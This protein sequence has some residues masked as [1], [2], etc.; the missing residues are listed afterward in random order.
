M[1]DDSVDLSINSGDKIQLRKRLRSARRALSAAQ[2]SDAA[3]KLLLRLLEIN[4]FM[5]SSRIA[6]YLANDGEI[7]PSKLIEWCAQNNR[8]GYLPIVRQEQE[9]NWL[10][11]AEVTPSSH[12][13]QNRFGIQ[14]PV[15]DESSWIEAR[16]LDLVLLPLVGFDKLGNRIGMGGGFY[17]TTFEFLKLERSV[18]K[19]GLIGVAHEIQKVEK[20]NT[21]SWDV[22]L[23][24]VVT[25]Q[26]IYQLGQ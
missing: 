7:D 3:D 2:Q 24:M 17:D 5:Q 15:V 23:T 14:E 10:E 8:Q 13:E 25:D 19:P 12:F 16:D 26:A 1:N 11:F 22:P 4:A 20:I 6:F 9:R 18:R 21:E